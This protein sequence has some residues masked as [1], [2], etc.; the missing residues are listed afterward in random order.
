MI[1][2][3][4]MLFCVQKRKEKLLRKRRSAGGRKWT[5][6]KQWPLGGQSRREVQGGVAVGRQQVVT[7][8]LRLFQWHVPS[9]GKVPGKAGDC[10]S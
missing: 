5:A 4:G 2:F 1:D 6:G 9:E 8:Y 10:P 3:C 7:F